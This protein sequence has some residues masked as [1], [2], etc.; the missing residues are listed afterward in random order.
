MACRDNQWRDEPCID[1][2]RP[3]TCKVCGH[4][5]T[6]VPQLGGRAHAAELQDVRGVHRAGAHQHLATWRQLSR[7]PLARRAVE[8]ELDA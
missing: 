1:P 5:N 8:R 2:S 3:P 4:R 7:Q 6:V